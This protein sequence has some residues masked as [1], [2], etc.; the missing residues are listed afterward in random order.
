VWLLRRRL[1]AGTVAGA[2]RGWVRIAV[3][4]AVLTLALVAAGAAWPPPATRPAEVAW[5]GVMIGGGVLVY[6]LAH[7]AL[8]SEELTGVVGALRRRGP[9]RR[10]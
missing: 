2:R 5:L 10:A 7:L 4:S 9:A 1:G 3:A 6:A 8:G